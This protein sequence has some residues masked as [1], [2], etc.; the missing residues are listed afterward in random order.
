MLLCKHVSKSYGD[1]VVLDGVSLDLNRG[2]AKVLMGHSG[3]GKTTL[4]RCLALL[5]SCDSG[6]VEIDNMSL[7]Y[8]VNPRRLAS[9]GDQVYPRVSLVFQQLFLWPNMTCR[10]NLALVSKNAARISTFAERLAVGQVLDRYPQACSLGQKQRIAVIRAILPSPHYLLCD[11][12]TSALDFQSA[13]MVL[14]L[15]SELT[16][17]DT[18]VL[19]ITHDTDLIELLH[20]CEVVRMEHGRIVG[21]HIA[22]HPSAARAALAGVSP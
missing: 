19:L 18:G 6:T 10:E 16:S 17:E 2:Q 22:P 7:S 3:C 9:I 8:P 21:Q 15:L 5:E 14:D 11:E 12:I 20:N 4:L 1:T 13:T